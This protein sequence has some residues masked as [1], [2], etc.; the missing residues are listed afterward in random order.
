MQVRSGETVICDASPYLFLPPVLEDMGPVNEGATN[1]VPIL[2]IAKYMS[3][4]YHFSGWT[5]TTEQYTENFGTPT[6]RGDGTESSMRKFSS[7]RNTKGEA[8]QGNE[9]RYLQAPGPLGLPWS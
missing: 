2:S 9:L 7:P 4:F 1:D 8:I 6:I 5:A 3:S